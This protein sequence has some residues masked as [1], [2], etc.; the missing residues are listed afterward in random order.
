MN[1]VSEFKEE[2]REAKTKSLCAKCQRFH[3]ISNE[4]EYY[5]QLRKMSSQIRFHMIHIF[6]CIALANRPT[7]SGKINKIQKSRKKKKTLTLFALDD[8]LKY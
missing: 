8:L 2:L 4:Y 7:K 3:F 1:E 5:D 6:G